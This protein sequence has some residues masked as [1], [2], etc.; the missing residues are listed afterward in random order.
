MMPISQGGDT[1][2]ER[3]LGSAK[4]D[5]ASEGKLTPSPAAMIYALISDIHGNLPALQAVLSD[6]VS[7]GAERVCASVMSLVMDRNQA[8]VWTSSSML[9]L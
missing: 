8:N 1:A 7:N 2:S 9:T 6:M 5:L 3:L 4:P